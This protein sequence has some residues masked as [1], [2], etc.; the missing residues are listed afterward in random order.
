MGHTYEGSGRS[1]KT[2]VRLITLSPGRMRRRGGVV[3]ID[4]LWRRSIRGMLSSLV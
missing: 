4:P 1:S 2:L 3:S